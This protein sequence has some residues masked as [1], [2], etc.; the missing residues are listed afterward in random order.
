MF[1]PVRTNARVTEY[2]MIVDPRSE[3][4]IIGYFA[5]KP[6]SERIVDIFG[7][8]FAYVGLACRR[9][10]GQFDADQ[11]KVGEFIADPGLVYRVISSDTDGLAPVR[12]AA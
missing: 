3:G 4:P 9:R 6:I 1:A 5:G 10:D 2:S 7:R 8:C 11:L 12:H